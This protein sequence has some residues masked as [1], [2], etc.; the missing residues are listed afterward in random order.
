MI[1][2]LSFFLLLFVVVSCPALLCTEAADRIPALTLDDCIA[3]VLADNPQIAASRAE[4][5][6]RRAVGSG[7]RKDLYPTLSGQYAYLHQPDAMILPGEQF[8]YGLVAEQPLYRGRA[9]V[10]AV[11]QADLAVETAA[12]DLEEMIN[13][14]VYE[15]HL[16]YYEL[17]RTTK[18]AEEAAQAVLR[19]QSHVR[20]ARA[21]YEAGLIPKNDM[22]QSE[23]ELA[24]GEQDLVDAETRLTL[25]QARLNILM[26]RPVDTPLQVSDPAEVSFPEPSWQ[27]AVREALARRPEMSRAEQEIVMAENDII[28]KKAPYLPSVSLSASYE[29]MGDEVSGAPYSHGPH[30]VKTIKAMASWKL[31]TWRQ[32]RDE[33]IAAKENLTKTKELA[34]TIRNEVTLDVRDAFLRLQQAEKRIAVTEKAI[35]HARENYRINKA[36]YQVQLATSTAV[37]DAQTLLTR[38]MT[39]YHDALYDY[40]LAV[41][42]LDRAKGAFATLSTTENE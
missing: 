39:N 7:V 38:A 40:R 21:F 33:V 16:R 35:E 3:A 36:Q 24:Q 8:S 34:I 28:L 2:K 1:T 9:L 27:N 11:R 5:A 12:S 13:S 41:A 14:L 42:A 25:A 32:D 20:D 10:T 30:E 17:L 4:L 18:Q 26:Q 23:V 19:L 22:L 31:W 37:L 15:A 6:R 29:R